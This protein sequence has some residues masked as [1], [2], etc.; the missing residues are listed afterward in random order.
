VSGRSRSSRSCHRTR[1]PFLKFARNAVA[2]AAYRALESTLAAI[3]MSAGGVTFDVSA[4]SASD[5][6]TG[7]RKFHLLGLGGSIVLGAG[8]IVALVAVAARGGLTVD[9]AFSTVIFALT[10][11]A[12][13]LLAL[14]G[15]TMSPGATEVRVTDTGIRLTYPRGRTKDFL[16]SDPGVKLTLYEFP[17]IMP[18]GGPFPFSTL[19]LVTRH[20]QSNP[21]TSAAFD[22]ILTSANSAG[23]R[24]TRS[25]SSFGTPRSVVRI[26][27]PAS[28]AR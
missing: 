25:K 5:Y 23:L 13:V 21:L 26:R 22:A 16:W 18:N 8:W 9:P 3:R 1:G 11:G 4:L 7:N 15:L 28:P 2:R 17:R 10:G 24:V 14:V 20:P 19:W 27:G 6:Q 12:V